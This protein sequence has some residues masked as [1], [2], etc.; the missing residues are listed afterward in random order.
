MDKTGQTGWPR[1]GFIRVLFLLLTIV[2]G[3]PA[4]AQSRVSLP[5]K[6]PIVPADI[7]VSPDGC[8]TSS[9]LDS[10]LLRR[11]DGA[12]DRTNR[13]SSLGGP[14]VTAMG[15]LIV[16]E[17]DGTFTDTNGG[18]VWD[19]DGSNLEF[20]PTAGMDGFFDATRGTAAPVPSLGT[21][22]ATWSG[23]WGEHII[24]LPFTFPFGTTN[25]TTLY[26]TSDIGVFFSS[27][28]TN[29]SG[30]QYGQADIQDNTVPRIA[31]LLRDSPWIWADIIDFY[32]R[33]DTSGSTDKV[34]M[35]WHEQSSRPESMPHLD[36]MFQLTLDDS[37][38]IRMDYPDARSY[39]TFGAV[40]VVAPGPFGTSL[41]DI[42]TLSATPT[43]VR[44]VRE[45]FTFPTLLPF[46]IESFVN[47][48][49][50][51]GDTNLDAL[52]I[53][54][55]HFTEITSYAGAY[56][57]NGRPG[58]TGIGNT[59]DKRT[60][61]LHM[62]QIDVSWNLRDDGSKVSV[63]SHELGHRWLFFIDGVGTSRAGGHP[64]QNAHLPAPFS[65]FTS[66]DSSCMGGATWT[67]NLDGTFTSPDTRT[68]Y[69][70]SWLELYLMGL[71]DPTEV[72]PWYYID[73]QP[74]LTGPYYPPVSSTF[75]GVKADLTITDVV[76]ANG[77]RDP[78]YPATQNEFR[79]GFVLL[80]RPENPA[81]SSDLANVREKMELW[82]RRW[83][84]SV[85]DRASL[86]TELTEIV[87]TG[88]LDCNFNGIADTSDIT[89]G[90]GFDCN[91][92]MVLDECEKLFTITLTPQSTSIPAGQDL[93]FDV[94]VVNNTN[95]AQS[96]D[97]WLEAFLP[98]GNPSNLNPVAGP[99]NVTLGPNQQVTR[100][101]SL[102]VPGRVNPSGPYT[103]QGVLGGF[104]DCFSSSSSFEFNVE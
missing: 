11:H 6:A 45:A 94:M 84:D 67:D 86:D 37:G 88:D 55:N 3:H 42:S 12:E 92:N 81:V 7:P 22:V 82:T 30:F 90:A 95:Q 60:S 68:Y 57:T 80:S 61:L 101:V 76:N 63:L 83:A 53:F 56:H 59:G 46:E 24:N 43:F 16:L 87:G 49:Y 10:Y 78:A 103:M 23:T 1:I 64:A 34:I 100:T 41:E 38:V 14:G 26:A 4:K 65:W 77:V 73:S 20:I 98:N 58:A 70:Y 9:E 72:P 75:S 93:V 85:N 21:L 74:A 18:S 31:P 29:S 5:R 71:A 27:Q 54:Q 36:R 51:L 52:A 50:S 28:P 91:G 32:V 13:R 62:N 47:S 96:F 40:Q 8:A 99:R 15:G 33:I 104:P 19:L 89:S 48:Q 97:G 69:A 66:I 25:Q 35:T 102:R 39:C 17:D 2:I 79:V 44:H